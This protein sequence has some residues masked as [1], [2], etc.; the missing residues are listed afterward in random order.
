MSS[1]EIRTLFEAAIDRMLDQNTVL[2]PARN[3]PGNDETTIQQ[4]DE[5]DRKISQEVKR[6]I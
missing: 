5:R 4:M 6:R 1:G 2:N 3:F